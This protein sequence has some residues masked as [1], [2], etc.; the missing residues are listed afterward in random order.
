MAVVEFIGYA[1]EVFG[2]SLDADQLAGCRTAAD[3]KALVA[4]R[5][6]S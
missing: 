5:L 2:K 4:D 3:L 6:D 1:D